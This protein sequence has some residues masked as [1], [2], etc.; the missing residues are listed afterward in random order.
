[1]HEGLFEQD[2]EMLIFFYLLMCS[3]G[4]ITLRSSQRLFASLLTFVRAELPEFTLHRNG[5]NG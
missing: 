3:A 2:F 4:Q 1:M 5:G